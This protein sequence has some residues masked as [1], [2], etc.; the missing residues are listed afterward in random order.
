MLSELIEAAVRT[1]NDA[2]A[3]DA[4]GRLADS[5]RPSETDWGRGISARCHA[6]VSRDETAEEHYR[7]AVECFS[8]TALRPEHAR[9]HLLYGE[10]LRRQNRRKDARAQL[11][12][13][14]NM[15]SEIGCSRSPNV[16]SMNV[17]RREGPSASGEK[18]RAT[19]SRPK[20]S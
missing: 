8:R 2:L 15:F 4:F 13:A 9:A 5:A 11:R 6:L 17:G 20:R 1:G 12:I 18:T 10:W 14:H 16:P 19:T 3:A 7:E